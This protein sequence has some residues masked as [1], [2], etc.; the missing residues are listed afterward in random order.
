MRIRSIQWFPVVTPVLNPAPLAQRAVIFAGLAVVFSF[1]ARWIP[2]DGFF[3]FD[4]VHFFGIGNIPVFYPPWSGYVVRWLTYP[5]LIGLTLAAVGLAAYL[6]SRHPL[7]LVCVFFALPVMWTVFL[8]QVDGLVLLGVLGLPWLAPLALLKPQ[9]SLWAFGARKSS[10]IALAITLL[11]SFLIWGFWPAQMFSIWTV[12]AEGKYINDIAVGWLGLPLAL[13]LFWF[14]RGDVDML[15][16]AGCVT[17]P[18][19]L[20][21]NLIV[22]APAIARLSPRSALIACAA[23]WLP[24]SANWLGDWGWWLGW[25]FMIWLWLGLAGWRYADNRLGR[26][27]HALA[28]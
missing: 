7:S 27:I 12:H 5:V 6:R 20:P 14:S 26:V 10:L 22:V 9:L 21:Y 13:V 25:L 24:F 17:T 3:A 18:Y 1:I 11:V 19:L 15:M 4:W 8:G 28:S 2:V 23:S 16:L